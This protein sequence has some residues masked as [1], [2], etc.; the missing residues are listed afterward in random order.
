MERKDIEGPCNASIN[1]GGSNAAVMLDDQSKSPERSQ[2]C[3]AE[4]NPQLQ[5]T[6]RL[7]MQS[8]E[9]GSI[10]GKRGEHIKTMRVDS[11]AHINISDGLTPERIVTLTGTLRS[12]SKAIAMINETL[13]ESTN[14]SKHHHCLRLVVPVV[15]CGSIIGRAGMR[16]N[17]LRQMTNVSINIGSSMLPSSTEKTVTICGLDSDLENCFIEICKFLMECPLKA[18]HIPYI[19][20][21]PSNIS[22][23]NSGSANC[24]VVFLN[25]QPYQVQTNQQYQAKAAQSNMYELIALHSNAQI[26]PSPIDITSPL[27]P[28]KPVL[29]DPTAS[30]RQ[31]HSIASMIHS[32]QLSVPNDLVGCVIGKGGQKINEIRHVSGATIKISDQSPDC[33]DRLIVLTGTIEQISVAEALIQSRIASEVGG[34]VLSG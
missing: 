23:S 6:V 15:Q 27:T 22:T 21:V 33:K 12:L 24:H 19:P 17:A 34:I 18:D 4:L 32:K 11:G 2:L 14:K 9:V 7:L 29:L 10:I 13:R 3:G 20:Y 8:K 30:S 26:S 16:I 25:G 5:T 1:G 28:Y 31:A